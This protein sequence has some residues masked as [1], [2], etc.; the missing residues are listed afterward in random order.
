[1]SFISL[2]KRLVPIGLKKQIK[3]RMQSGRIVDRVSAVMP[4]VICI[5]VGASYYP[6]VRWNVFL[7]SKNTQWFA[8][9][10]NE[11]NLGYIQSWH[12]P[13]RARAI[14]TGLSE[15]GG[16]QTLYITN[17][18]SGSSLLEPAIAEGM[19]HRVN[20]ASMEYFFPLRTVE[21]DTLTLSEV[22]NMGSA[23]VPVFVKLD[24]QGS[25][26]S[27]LRG[28]ASQLEGKRVVGIEMESTLLAQPLM[29]GSGKFWEACQ[30]LESMGFELLDIHPIQAPSS[31]GK[32]HARG[33][34]FLNEC[35]AVFALRRDVVKEMPVEY[36]I[37]LFSFYLA[38]T[39][40]EE[41]LSIMNEDEEV[42]RYLQA[43]GL[44]L[45]A[46]SGLMI[47]LA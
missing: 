33:K 19:R 34:R 20:K 29:K 18:D 12:R 8:V 1:M 26:L 31:L 13:S 4:E 32:A 40:F 42:R 23:T 17:V 2:V 24:T 22:I 10:P 37:G 5:D 47:A 43:K 28:A 11:Q 44:D 38:N 45:E 27:I 9:E 6:H 25:E 3:K 41:A 7:E 21:I 30:Y 14:T 46:L 36:R 35:D 16:R 39:L 15:K